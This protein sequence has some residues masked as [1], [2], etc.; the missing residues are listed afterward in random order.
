MVSGEHKPSREHLLNKQVSS[1][2]ARPLFIA[3]SSLPQ[4]WHE[5]KA[6]ARTRA[7]YKTW[8]RF[9]L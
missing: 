7:F 3:F 9:L 4:L 8:G 6:L 1:V 5:H 2:T